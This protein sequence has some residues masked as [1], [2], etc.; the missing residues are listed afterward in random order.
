MDTD[1]ENSIRNNS[2]KLYSDFLN[3]IQ[4][5]QDAPNDSTDPNTFQQREFARVS[6]QLLYDALQNN[7]DAFKEIL[8]TLPVEKPLE[9]PENVI[10]LAAHRP[11]KG[12]ED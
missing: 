2:F 5:A 1:L 11:W 3:N 8:K 9:F 6:F 12:Q 10:D 7:K 4:I